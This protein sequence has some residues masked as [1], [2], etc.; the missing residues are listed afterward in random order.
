VA[1]IFPSAFVVLDVAQNVQDENLVTPEVDERN[2]AAPIVADIEDDA[3]PDEI[4]A[5][6]RLAHIGKVMPIGGSSHFVP[7]VQRCFPLPVLFD[8]L[9]DLSSANDPHGKS[10]H[11]AKSK[12]SPSLLLVVMPGAEAR[13]PAADV[14]SGECRDAGQGLSKTNAENG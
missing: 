2:Q 12:S 11:I 4:G 9:T 7:G 8:R 13:E 14:T 6:P 10:S 5:L 1:I 3:R